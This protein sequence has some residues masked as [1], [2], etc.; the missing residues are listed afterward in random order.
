MDFNETKN[1]YRDQI[2]QSISFSGKGLDYFTE[3]KADYLKKIIA[4]ELPSIHTPKLLDVGCGH[5]Y[6]HP[7]LVEA[8]FRVSG[9]EVASE[10]LPYAERANPAVDYQSYDGHTLPFADHTF[11]VVLTICVM[12][13]VPP[14]N[15][16]GFVNEALRVLKPGGLFVVFEH[17]PYN[18]LTRY[19]VASNAIDD[20]AVL[21]PPRT[22]SN[23]LTKAGFTHIVSRSI[24]FTPFSSRLFKWMDEKLGRLPLGAQYYL[25]GKR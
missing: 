20:D 15:W 22:T 23:L 10:V 12:H 18:P 1:S 2:E 21:L 17:N 11:D 9:V 6:I 5:G 13:H 14:Q 16:Q 8:G 19:V 3:V 25:Y 24:L 7:R 4:E